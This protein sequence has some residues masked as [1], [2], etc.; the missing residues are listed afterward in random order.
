MKQFK[1]IEERQKRFDLVK[2][3]LKKARI[4]HYKKTVAQL[5]MELGL[6][7][8][9]VQEYINILI[10]AKIVDFDGETLEYIEDKG[11][12]NDS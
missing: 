7:E 3:I 12:N 9:K 10:S 8:K 5:S 2:A 4:S 11:V 1:A 6:T